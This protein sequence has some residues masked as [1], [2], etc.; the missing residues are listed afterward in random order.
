MATSPRTVLVLV[1]A[2]KFDPLNDVTLKYL[3][4][5][6]TLH[7]FENQNTWF[8]PGLSAAITQEEQLALAE[9][10]DVI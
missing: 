2:V 8:K 1:T 6:M 9:S 7:G 5:S 3:V 10:D 4:S